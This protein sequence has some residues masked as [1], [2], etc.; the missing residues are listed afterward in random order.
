[1]QT[2]VSLLLSF[3]LEYTETYLT[4]ILTPQIDSVDPG[5]Q[6]LLKENT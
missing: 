6:N 1:L 2:L 5:S 4:W 3:D